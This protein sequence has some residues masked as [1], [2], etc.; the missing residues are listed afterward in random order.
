MAADRSKMRIAVGRD[1]FAHDSGGLD[2]LHLQSLIWQ[3]RGGE[4]RL[5]E[6]FACNA[7][8]VRAFNNG[9]K[10]K[11]HN[12]GEKSICRWFSFTSQNETLD[13]IRAFQS[14]RSAVARKLRAP[15]EWRIDIRNS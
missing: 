10:L 14:D 5:R 9:K 3:W 4:S 6:H 13:S 8:P 11:R 2:G 7:G 1:Q 12:N 15:N